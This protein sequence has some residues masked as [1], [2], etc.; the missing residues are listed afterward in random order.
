MA[1]FRNVLGHEQAVNSLQNAIML[2]K[3]SHAYIINGEDGAGKKTLADAFAM[4]LQ[5]EKG[6][7]DACLEC[8]SCK[9]AMTRNQPD[10]IYLKPEK[11]NLISVSDIRQQINAD[12]SIK[13]YSSRYKIYIINHA[14]RMNEAAQNAI[15]KTIEEPPEYVIILLL[16]TNAQMLLPTIR[17][18]CITIEVRPVA[19]EI[20]KDYLMKT[21]SVPEDEAAICTAFAQGNVGKAARLSGSEDFNHIRNEAVQLLKRIKNIDLY[22][23]VQAVKVIGEYKLEIDDYFDILSIWYRDVLVYKATMDA[24]KL[25]FQDEIY[26]IKKQAATSSYEGIERIL[27]AIETAKTRVKA[28]VN[29][30]LTLE[31]LLLNIKEN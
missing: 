26:D 2:G 13:P 19:D 29:L 31:L 14:E 27:K 25:V 12:V 9:Q 1:G 7:K 16:T 28:N 22:E 15:L 20:V 4:T 17:S 24:N 21:L 18:R 6:T 3:V 11:E 8:H 30:E 23:L 10:I 5:C